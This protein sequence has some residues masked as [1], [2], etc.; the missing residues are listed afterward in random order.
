ML[1]RTALAAAAGLMVCAPTADAMAH[2]LKATKDTVHWGY[3]SKMVKPALTIASG[4]TVTVEMVSVSVRIRCIPLALVD[5]QVRAL[6]R[7]DCASHVRP[8]HCN[9]ARRHLLLKRRVPCR[10]FSLLCGVWR[11]I[12]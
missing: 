2:T 1:R 7:H 4:D 11:A 10:P 6:L 8:R 3:F 12:S 5:A 9:S